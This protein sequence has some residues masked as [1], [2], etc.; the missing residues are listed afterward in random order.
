ML[1]ALREA[2]SEEQII[3]PQ[4]S[5]AFFQIAHLTLSVSWLLACL[6]QP[7][8]SW[9]LSQPCLFIFKIPTYRGLVWQGLMLVL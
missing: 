6:E 8:V 5:Q 2:L 1:G 4:V 7:R 3:F 9:A